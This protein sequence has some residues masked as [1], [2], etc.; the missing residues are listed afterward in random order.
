MLFNKLK[1]HNF[2]Q[3]YEDH[4]ITFS[5]SEEKNVTVILGL[6]SFGKSTLLNAIHWGLYGKPQK[7]FD[8][9]DELLSKPAQLKGYN[10]VF[11]ELS[12]RFEEKDYLLRRSRKYSFKAGGKTDYE[13][14]SSLLTIDRESGRAMP[15]DKNRIAPIINKAIPYEMADAFIFHGESRAEQLKRSNRKQ[16]GHAIRQI[17]GCYFAEVVA[18]DLRKVAKK[19]EVAVA[20]SGAGTETERNLYLAIE[21]RENQ[22]DEA[23]LKLANHRER[24][25]EYERRIAEIDEFLRNNHN[26]SQTQNLIDLKRIELHKK[27]VDLTRAENDLRTWLSRQGSAALA[28][29][30]CNEAEDKIDDEELRGRIP[31]EYQETFIQNLLKTGTCICGREL[32]AHGDERRLVESLLGKSTNAVVID[33]ALKTKVAI[34]SLQRAYKTAVQELNELEGERTRLNSEIAAYEAEI[35]SLNSQITGASIDEIKKRAGER[36]H[37]N[38]ERSKLLTWCG[39][40]S[41]KIDVDL[42]PQLSSLKAERSKLEAKKPSLAKKTLIRDLSEYLGRI[43]Q[44]SIARYE[45]EARARIQ[46]KINDNIRGMYSEYEAVL[47]E[48]FNLGLR[49]PVTKFELTRSDGENQLLTLAFTAALISECASRS[50]EKQGLM[51][52]GTVAPLVLDSPYGQ[53]DKHFQD[54]VNENIPKLARQVILLVSDSQAEQLFN[55]GARER[56]GAQYRLVKEIAV[57]GKTELPP[58]RLAGCTY[59]SWKPGTQDAVAIERLDNPV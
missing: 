3:F 1:L 15:I 18:G 23:N 52:P 41:R 38:R 43:L 49:N 56:V 30:L 45:N 7:N 16:V 44:E 34:Q 58:Y 4:E 31:S 46:A 21:S 57:G 54:S 51:I 35:S 33:S 59:T 55:S 29:R 25:S 39:D 28:L 36:E 6:N 47:A 40:L 27:T 10:D 5:I 50:R 20:E 53:L 19:L 22:L 13:D 17:L 2:R 37:L 42:K 14:E 32:S 26:T 24:I 8:R 11:V 48:D 12:F 9:P